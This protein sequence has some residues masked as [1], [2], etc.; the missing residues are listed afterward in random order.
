MT[1][2]EVLALRYDEPAAAVDLALWCEGHLEEA[3]DG[4]PPVIWIPGK[5]GPEAAVVGTWVVRY[6][7]GQ[8]AA[9]SP[10]QFAATFEPVVDE[11]AT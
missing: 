3:P 7:D 10:R 11:T 8:W 5:D 9:L 2:D 1:R 6:A 4:G